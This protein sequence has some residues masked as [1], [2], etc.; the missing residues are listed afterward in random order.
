MTKYENGLFIFRRDFRVIDNKGLNLANSLCKKIYPVFIF[1]PEQVTNNKFKSDNAVQFMIE[2]LEDLSLQIHKMNGK[3]LTFYGNNNQIIP[4]L[5]K[6]LNINLLSFNIDFTPYAIQRDNE[7]VDICNKSGVDIVNGFDYYL[8]SPGTILNS[9]GHSYQKFTPFYNESLK[10]K[11]DEPVRLHKIHFIN[12]NEKNDNEKTHPK[13]K[14]IISLDKALKRFTN[15]NPNIL[16]HGGRSNAIK[17]LRIASKNIINYSKTRSELS[18][19]SSQLSAYIKFGCLS[20][21]E[22]YKTFRSNRD[23]IRQL[24]WRDFYANIIFS[25]PYVLG[26]SLKPKYDKIK[27]HNNE[28]WFRD[29]ING[30]T[31]FPV[32]DAGIRELNSTG[33]MH[34]RARL[35]VMTFL[36]KTL[37]IDWQKGEKYFASKLTDYDPASNNGNTQW[38]MGGGADSSPYYRIFNPW[39]QTEHFDP[40]CIYIKKW[41]PEL[42]NVP[43]EDIINWDTE[44]K[45]Y[46]DVDYFKPICD[47]KIQ[48]EK[49]LKMYKDALY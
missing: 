31:G 11:V 38:V 2:S 14:N 6:E 26:G 7:I 3:L 1:T 29:W 47:Y 4:Y 42:S 40:D 45:N 25:F 27:W 17:Q 12:D 28:R 37:L 33:Y 41:I 9:T 48:K 20:I 49:A 43:V 46:K 18:H 13:L 23:F 44:Y 5:I 24:F 15:N 10:K 35:I 34:N 16:V 21:R 22:V 19:P 8:H 32:I 36:I 39:L 30:E